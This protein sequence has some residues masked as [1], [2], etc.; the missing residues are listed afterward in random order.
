[1]DLVL[2][3][4]ELNPTWTGKWGGEGG[5]VVSSHG[6]T[7]VYMPFFNHLFNCLENN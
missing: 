7:N 1:M 4:F 6:D 3:L 5:G 2:N